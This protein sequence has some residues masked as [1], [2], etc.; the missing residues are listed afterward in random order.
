MALSL[1]LVKW[2]KKKQRWQVNDRSK[3]AIGAQP[4]SNDG[5]LAVL[6]HKKMRN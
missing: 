2:H 1:V 6:P 5:R 3:Q 4:R